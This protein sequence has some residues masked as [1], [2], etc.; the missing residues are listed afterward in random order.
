VPTFG[1]A[2]PLE[3][4]LAKFGCTAANVLAAAYGQIG[5]FKGEPG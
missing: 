1:S 5:K 4:L 2:V 3:D